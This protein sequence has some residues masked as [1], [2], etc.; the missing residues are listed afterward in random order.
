MDNT[1]STLRHHNVQAQRYGVKNIKPQLKR[2]LR[3]QRL[4]IREDCPRDIDNA[5][6]IKWADPEP[7]RIIQSIAFLIY[8]DQPEDRLAK[9]KPGAI[10]EKQQSDREWDAMW[11][12][13][14]K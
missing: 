6:L 9:K 5:P 4:A 13:L 7:H 14:F 1:M 12:G 11:G 10:Y 2:A 8:A 3:Y